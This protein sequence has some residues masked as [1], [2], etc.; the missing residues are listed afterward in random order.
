VT[1]SEANPATSRYFSKPLSGGS[2]SG[3]FDVSEN[4]RNFNGGTMFWQGS[5]AAAENPSCSGIRRWFRAV[6]VTIKAIA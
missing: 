3:A 1:I 6:D 2:K 4:Q 5:I